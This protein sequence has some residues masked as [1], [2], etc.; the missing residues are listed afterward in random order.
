MSTGTCA[1]PIPDIVGWWRMEGNTRNTR[2][3]IDGISHARRVDLATSMSCGRVGQGYQFEG[4]N[5]Y[6]RQTLRSR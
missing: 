6:L 5:G 2:S 1:Y 4:V 3:S